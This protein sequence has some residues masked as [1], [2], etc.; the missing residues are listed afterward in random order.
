VVGSNNIITIFGDDEPSFREISHMPDVIAIY[1]RHRLI[2]QHLPV[3]VF[4]ATAYTPIKLFY[5]KNTVH[6]PS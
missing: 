3:L 1:L 6:H 5:F 2:Y 4:Y